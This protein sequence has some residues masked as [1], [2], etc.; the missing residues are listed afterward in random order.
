MMDRCSTF[1]RILGNGPADV[2]EYYMRAALVIEPSSKKRDR[3]YSDSDS[4]SS[5][6]G[7]GE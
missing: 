3:D 1:F 6:V 4:V 7:S 2:E 5:S